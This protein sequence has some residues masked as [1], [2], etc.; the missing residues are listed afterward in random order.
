MVEM[1]NN[2][3]NKDNILEELKEQNINL[4]DDKETLRSR[5]E[6]LERQVKQFRA[7]LSDQY[8]ET[9]G[10]EVENAEA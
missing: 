10:M 4:A 2:L 5:L 9:E 1:S 3:Q 6:T 7:V 8:N